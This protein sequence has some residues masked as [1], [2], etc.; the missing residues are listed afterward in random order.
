VASDQT[1]GFDATGLAFH[2][3]PDDP[4]SYCD[5]NRPRVFT[6][7]GDRRNPSC[8]QFAAP[9]AA[10]D[11]S[12]WPEPV[13]GCPD[14]VLSNGQQRPDFHFLADSKAIKAREAAIK[15]FYDAGGGLF[16]G[17]GADNGDGHSAD[18]YYA[19]VDLPGGS[20]GA[21][22]NGDI[23]EDCLG[24]QSGNFALTP[25]GAALGFQLPDI[26]CGSG[27]ACA[28][29]NSFKLPRVGSSLLVA[30]TEPGGHANTVFQDLKAPDTI[31]T[32]GPGPALPIKGTPPREE[33][34][35]IE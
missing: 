30:E 19:F 4:H 17:S 3:A 35:R 31:I 25:E 16:L 28:T 10:T 21:A 20:T 22:C 26:N 12:I 29:H 32:G 15:S 2:G 33:C 1:C 27:L 11:R 34:P 8:F 5:L 9:P 24:A 13:E 14:D 18:T 6:E 7:T 23:G